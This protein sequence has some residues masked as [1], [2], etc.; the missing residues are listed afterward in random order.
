[1]TEKECRICLEKDKIN[2]FIH[3]CFCDGT[4]KWVHSSCLDTWRYMNINERPYKQCMECHYIYKLKNVS[5]IETNIINIKKN[6]K[7]RS[8]A[9]WV[10]LSYPLGFFIY[11]WDHSNNYFSIN[12]LSYNDSYLIEKFNEKI[13][14]DNFYFTLYYNLLTV[15]IF[16][17][18]FL[19]LLSVY[20]IEKIHRKYIYFTCIIKDLLVVF[21][22]TNHMF[23]LFYPFSSSDSV[24]FYF[25]ISPGL[26]YLTFLCYKTLLLRN[27]KII[28]KMNTKFNKSIVLNYE[29]NEIME[30]EEEIDLLMDEQ[31]ELID[32]SETKVRSEMYLEIMAEE[33]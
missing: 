28:M 27:N 29:A 8:F 6:T 12:V 14:Y 30:D 22:I 7:I 21:L 4:S 3:P 16:E 19:L 26:T 24:S 25:F 11:L 17:N 10:I 13:E 5:P 9:F 15:N 18:I 31:N 32:N 1:M 23:Y 33:G 2:E 20:L